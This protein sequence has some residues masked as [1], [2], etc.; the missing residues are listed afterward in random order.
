MFWQFYKFK[1]PTILK[2]TPDIY[3]IRIKSQLKSK[4]SSKPRTN[5]TTLVA[6]PCC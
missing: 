4:A 6:S 5:Q 1:E 3:E 2:I